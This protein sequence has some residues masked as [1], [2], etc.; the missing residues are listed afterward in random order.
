MDSSIRSFSEEAVFLKKVFGRTS[1]KKTKKP[2]LK[3]LEE[4]YQIEPK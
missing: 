4:L 3:H 1:T 2:E